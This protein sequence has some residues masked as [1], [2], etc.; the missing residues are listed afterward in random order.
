MNDV[1]PPDDVD[2][3]RI[4]A[5]APRTGPGRYVLYWMTAQRRTTFSPALSYAVEA[6]R[7]T[8]RP[9][10]VFEPLDTHYRWASERMHAFVI[11]GM[12]DNQAAFAA[13]GVT[14]LPFVAAQATSG[15]GLLRALARD[16]SVVIADLHPGFRWPTLLERAQRDLPC[17]L[18]AID[19]CG[20]LPLH[21]PTKRYHRAVDFRRLIHKAFAVDPPVFPQQNP[22]AGYA[23]GQATVDRTLI[24]TPDLDALSAP[25]GLADLPIRHDVPAVPDKPGG[26]V[27]AERRLAAFFARL[28]RYTERNHPDA[29]ASSGLSPWL[30]F[31]HIGAAG[32]VS[33]LLDRYRWSP[34]HMRAENVAKQRGAWGMSEGAEAFLEELVTWRE[35]SFH[36]AHV[37]PDGHEVYDG[38]PAWAR[39][40]LEE[41]ADD[42]REAHY[43]VEILARAQTHDPLWN[44]AQRELVETGVMHNYLRMLWGKRVL[45]WTRH[46]REAFETLVELNNRYALDGRDPNSYGGIGWVFGRHDRPWGPE[47]PIYGK[48][49]YMTSDATRRKLDLK[50][51]Y[52]R[53]GRG[54]APPPFSLGR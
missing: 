52:A 24:P 9:L 42:P 2:R 40:S 19:G 50:T 31:G 33:R 6:A 38:L 32:I 12:K 8:N 25:G 21:L 44:A 15:R 23:L 5:F 28:E 46:P 35:L 36:T 27:E 37:D 53:W 29:E 18:V 30:H 10:V 26:Q 39:A 41:H 51:W 14:Y 34:T 22:L 3:R 54:E 20:V 7:A 11:G 48:I 13:A 17:P 16:A 47:R 45:A 43:D 4:H 49:R 1:L